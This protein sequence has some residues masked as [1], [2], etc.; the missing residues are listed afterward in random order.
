[1]GILDTFNPCNCGR[2]TII[3]SN[4]SIAWARCISEKSVG[5]I[6]HMIGCTRVKGPGIPKLITRGI[7]SKRGMNRYPEL[8]LIE[9]NLGLNCQVFGEDASISQYHPCLQHQVLKPDFAQLH[10]LVLD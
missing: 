5:G 7:Q 1:M 3:D 4:F 9:M 2:S 8:V 6:C 10:E